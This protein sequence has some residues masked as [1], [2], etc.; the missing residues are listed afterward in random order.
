MNHTLRFY[1]TLIRIVKIKNSGDNTCWRGYGE[2]GTLL[3]CCWDCKLVEPL[4]KSICRLLKK[5]EID[6][7]EDPVILLLGIY[8]K[9]AP[10][11][12]KGTF[13]ILFIVSLFDL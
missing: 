11:C 12:H 9:D 6:L 1:L 4:W 8:P 13:S 7:L 10:P 5:L 2:R 3:L